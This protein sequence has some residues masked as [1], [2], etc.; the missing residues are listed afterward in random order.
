[1]ALVDTPA[2][3][4]TLSRMA[5]SR[6]GGSHAEPRGG[7]P[8]DAE[9]LGGL[10]GGVP[11][12]AVLL[13]VFTIGLDWS[14]VTANLVAVYDH[15][16]SRLRHEPLLGLGAEDKNRFVTE[17][18]P[19]WVIT[20]I[21]L[22]LS[23]IC[24]PLRRPLVRQLGLAVNVANAVGFGLVWVFKYLFLDRVMFGGRRHFPVDEDLE[25]ELDTAPAPRT[26][27][28]P[29]SR[30]PPRLP[31]ASCPPTRAWPSTRRPFG[32]GPARCSRSAP[33]A[34]SRRSTSVPLPAEAGTVLFTVDHHRGSEENQ[35]GWEH[36]E[37]DLVDPEVGLM[38]T[39]PHFRRTIYDAGLE[40][41]V[42]AIVGESATVGRAT[43]RRRSRS[44]SSTVATVPSPPTATTRA[45][46]PTSC[47]GGILAIHDV[48]PDPADGGRPPYELYC[49]ALE[50]TAFEEVGATGSLRVLRR[51]AEGI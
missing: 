39:L 22:V 8:Q 17:V 6:R 50:S 7:L 14:F 3:T 46:F 35:A 4:A 9:V 45:G 43:G 26:P 16:L 11:L 51:V 15:G 21:G 23:T 34:A 28:T 49:R 10:R 2:P 42:V 41:A 32:V 36:H 37:A 47:V 20:L 24:A 12:H 1:M 38:D 27:W 48:F 18:L 19:F 44:S 40:G 5:R 25:A 30:P 33:T 31:G 29:A 13:L